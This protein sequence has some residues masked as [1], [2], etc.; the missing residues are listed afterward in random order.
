MS[1]GE[2]KWKNGEEREEGGGGKE[3]ERRGRIE[4]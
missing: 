3:D 1:G 4:Q 2:N